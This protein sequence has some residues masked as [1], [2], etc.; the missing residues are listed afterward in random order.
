MKAFKLLLV[1]LG[2]LVILTAGVLVYLA[3]NLNSIVKNMVETEGPK[4]TQTAVTLGG[5]DIE[6]RK[7]R[8]E[9]T[10]LVIANPPQFTS[11][12]AV[13]AEQLILRLEPR[14]IMGDVV[15]I[16]EIV[17]DGV[18]VTAEQKGL[19]TNLQ[20]LL[21]SIQEAVARDDAA[22][23]EESDL[24]LMVEE[25]RFANSKLNLIS[26]DYGSR[27]VD[28]AELRL[29]DIGDKERGLTP[30]ELGKAIAEPVIRQA[31]AAAEDHL[32]EMARG[33]AEDRLKEEAQKRLG[34]DAEDRLKNLRDRLN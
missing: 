25:I 24:R 5:V 8:G 21:K 18:T 3:T 9:L 1:L 23:E 15:I 30:A 28:L 27:V 29:N 19:T 6:P 20:T 33:K 34:D 31:R 22:P 26:E 11:P 10:N 32:K 4:L 14:S 2:L 17:I 13:T 7:G 12:E 16:N